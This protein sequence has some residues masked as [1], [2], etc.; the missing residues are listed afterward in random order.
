[1]RPRAPILLRDVER[2]LQRARSA[3]RLLPWV[4]VSAA[5][6][7]LLGRAAS[8]EWRA[9]AVLGA[10]GILLFAFVAATAVARCPACGGSLLRRGERPGPAGSP[11]PV[12]AE[13][14][15]RCPRCQAP[16]E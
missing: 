16:F 9:A 8:G 15:R 1:V 3:R 5:G 2:E 6:A 12:E 10:F 4:V 13:R 11:S 7:G 14:A